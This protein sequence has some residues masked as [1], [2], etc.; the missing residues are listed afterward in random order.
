[1]DPETWKDPIVFR[2]ERFLDDGGKVINKDLVV[3]F[4][5]GRQAYIY[6]YIYIYILYIYTY[7]Y[8]YICT[9]YYNVSIEARSNLVN[10]LCRL[11]L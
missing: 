1:M 8:I 9:V 10:N 5:M 4:S 11:W 6:N 3:P 7:I 2:P